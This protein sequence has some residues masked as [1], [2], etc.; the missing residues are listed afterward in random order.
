MHTFDLSLQAL[1]ILETDVRQ[2]LTDLSCSSGRT[3]AP[4]S[5]FLSD[6]LIMQLEDLN[7]RIRIEKS[8]AYEQALIKTVT[9]KYFQPYPALSSDSKFYDVETQIHMLEHSRA[10][11]YRKLNKAYEY[12]LHLKSHEQHAATLFHD[13]GTRP[14]GDQRMCTRIEKVQQY[15]DRQTAWIAKQRTTLYHLYSKLPE[16]L[17]YR[18]IIDEL[19][20][21]LHQLLRKSMRRS[22][23]YLRR[24]REVH[25][26]A[27]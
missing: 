18:T 14:N 12:L 11:I 25:A 23:C 10:L 2:K 19:D 7:S 26:F 22:S 9:A 5:S 6:I 4:Q 24:N 27:A 3:D 21:E 16:R 1:T 13:E 20:V 8:R 17:M 15:I